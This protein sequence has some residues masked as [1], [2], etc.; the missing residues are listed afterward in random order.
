MLRAVAV[1]NTLARTLVAA[2]AQGLGK[3]LLKRN[4]DRLTHPRAQ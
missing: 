1:A 2:A 3:L 4:L